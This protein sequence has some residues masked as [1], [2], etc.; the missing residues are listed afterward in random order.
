MN[1]LLTK[2]ETLPNE[3]LVMIGEYCGDYRCMFRRVNRLLYDLIPM[4]RIYSLFML[5]DEN[6]MSIAVWLHKNK[7]VNQ[8]TI[9]AY[10]ANKRYFERIKILRNIGW[11]WDHRVLDSVASSGNLDMF[12]WVYHHYCPVSP[13]T[14]S[15]AIFSG[16]IDLVKWMIS[17]G[18]RA[19][20]HFP[21]T[22]NLELYIYCR[23]KLR[24][25]NVKFKSVVTLDNSDILEWEI[26]SGNIKINNRKIKN[27]FISINNIIWF[28]E[29]QYESIFDNYYIYHAIVLT[30]NLNVLRNLV[31]RDCFNYKKLAFQSSELQSFDMFREYLKICNTDIEEIKRNVSDIMSSEEISEVFSE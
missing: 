12:E 22:N 6:W 21:Q 15:K 31:N 24:M 27:T 20:E 26:L 5:K 1:F 7:K 30:K 19:T 25:N 14:M 23:T 13:N 28:A 29:H 18:F 10:M 4:S 2:M 11:L 8:K 16:N 9:M 17:K 3:I